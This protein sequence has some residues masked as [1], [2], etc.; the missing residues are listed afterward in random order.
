MNT[1]SKARTLIASNTYSANYKPS[2]KYVEQV[3]VHA[4]FLVETPI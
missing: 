4:L 1:F 3:E 2:D